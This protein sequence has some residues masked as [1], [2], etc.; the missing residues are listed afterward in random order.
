[1]PA[2]AQTVGNCRNTVES[3]YAWLRLIASVLLGT[4]GSV[5]IWSY[6]VALPLVQ[7][8]FGIT[9]ADASLAYTLTMV[10]FGA[11]AAVIGSLADRFG[12]VAPLKGAVLTLGLGY[13]ASGLAPSSKQFALANLVIGFGS[14]AAF[15]PLIAD[16]SHWFTSSARCRKIA[17][18]VC[19]M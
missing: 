16:I 3:T 2:S 6:V 14:S 18:H 8:D 4:V 5:G 19:G 17:Q 11:G 10:G 9:R 13:F 7:A 1:M 15:A 12:I